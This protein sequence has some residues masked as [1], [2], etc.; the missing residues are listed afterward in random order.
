[1]S[2]KSTTLLLITALLVIGLGACSS[3]T[4]PKHS[5]TESRAAQKAASADADLTEAQREAK[6][7][8]LLQMAGD[9][10]KE[11][12]ALDPKAKDKVEKAYA[13]AVF[14]DYIYNAVFYVAG[15]GSGVAF[16]N[17]TKAPEYML[18]LRA[19]TGPGVGYTKFRQVLIIKN[20]TIYKEMTTVGFDVEASAN[21]TFKVDNFGGSKLYSGSFNP[22]LEVYTITDS[23]IDLQANW[24]G[25]EYIKNPGLN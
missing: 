10:L 3:M 24:G 12:Y 4:T 21:A 20:E 22:Y 8:A 17:S 5:A 9:T 7:Q 13:Y 18:M 14:D 16:R 1:M 23:G 25:V 6:R 2:I 11:I 19:G 15:Q